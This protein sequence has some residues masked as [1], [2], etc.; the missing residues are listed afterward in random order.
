MGVGS[1][2]GAFRPWVSS[3]SYSSRSS[4][5]QAATHSLQIHTPGPAISLA[6]WFS[7]LPQKLQR[8]GG[9]SLFLAMRLV[10]RFFYLS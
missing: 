5:L 6:A 2:S 10:P 4:S 8:M 1:R 3:R 9:C 7:R